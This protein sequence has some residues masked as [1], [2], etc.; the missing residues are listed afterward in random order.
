MSNEKPETAS[1]A[2]T[3]WSGKAIEFDQLLSNL[4][5]LLPD[6]G[7]DG[8][9]PLSDSSLEEVQRAFA[10]ARLSA[11]TILGA[12]TRHTFQQ[13]AAAQSNGQGYQARW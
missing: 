4:A 13:K 11:D 10:N 2:M 12:Y 3:F 5:E 7:P 9:V 1:D 6:T 8:E